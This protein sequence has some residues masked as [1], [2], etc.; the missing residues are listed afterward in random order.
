MANLLPCLPSESILLFSWWKHLILEWVS[1]ELY[2]SWKMLVQD[3]CFLQ[4]LPTANSI[5]CWCHCDFSDS[6]HHYPQH[7][8]IK[9]LHWCLWNLYLNGTDEAVG[10][11]NS[12][13]KAATSP[14]DVEM[15]VFISCLTISWLLFTAFFFFL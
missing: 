12:S 6:Q 7:P 14:T 4:S 1:L 2:V 11:R 10:P 3:Y 13:I 8:I 5:P 9:N 15:A